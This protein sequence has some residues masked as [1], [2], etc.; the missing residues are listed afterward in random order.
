M[1]GRGGGHSVLHH[2]CRGSLNFN[3]YFGGGR[4]MFM[5]SPFHF[6]DPLPLVIFDQSLT[7]QLGFVPLKSNLWAVSSH[8]PCKEFIWLVPTGTCAPQ[9]MLLY[10][11]CNRLYI[12]RRVYQR[13]FYN[14]A[15][16]SERVYSHPFTVWKLNCHPPFVS[17]WML[18]V[19]LYL[20]VM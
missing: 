20:W 10:P 5:E 14:D 7:R 19:C 18:S 13:L 3:F 1:N 16:T 9:G 2:H 17:H 12:H 15:G 6:T 4:S 8:T 11:A